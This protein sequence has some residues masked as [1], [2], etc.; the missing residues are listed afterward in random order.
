[1]VKINKIIKVSGAILAFGIALTPLTSYAENPDEVDVNVIVNPVI[2]MSLSSVSSVT[3]AA[4]IA[5]LT[6]M[7]TTATVNTNSIGGYTLTLRDTGSN[8][9][10]DNGA[11]TS[12][13]NANG[14]EIEAKSG[15]PVAS[16]AQWSIQLPGSDSWVALPAATDT[17][18]MVRNHASATEAIKNE[19]STVKY[20][21]ST[22]SSPVGLYSNMVT[23]TA[24]TRNSA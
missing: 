18:L 3:L 17:P 9:A 2:D 13:T 11:T 12:L 21:V 7:S 16:S 15:T 23:Y 19:T 20:G 4:N 22:G 8:A 24:T 5:D 14:D 6:T 1:M 10:G